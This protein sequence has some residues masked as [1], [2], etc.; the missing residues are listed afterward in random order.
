MRYLSAALYL[1]TAVVALWWGLYEVMHA[2]Y[3][4]RPS[5]WHLLIFVGGVVL[6]AG[7]VMTLISSGTLAR[8]VVPIG[9]ALLL[10]YFGPAV[11]VTLRA[12]RDTA[13]DWTD[14]ASVIGTAVLIAASAVAATFGALQARR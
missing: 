7:A 11:F 1:L 3:G 12:L 5:W 2:V 13:I 10:V 9:L 6:L 14:W 8:W 4:V